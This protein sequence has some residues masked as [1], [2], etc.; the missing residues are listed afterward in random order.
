[1]RLQWIV[2]HPQPLSVQ[3]EGLRVTVTATECCRT[4]DI[5]N[6]FPVD[7]WAP[8]EQLL[9]HLRRV[10][11]SVPIVH[12]TATVHTL[13]NVAFPGVMETGECETMWFWSCVGPSLIECPFAASLVL[14][15][16]DQP[17]VSSSCHFFQIWKIMSECH[18][19][20]ADDTCVARVTLN[21]FSLTTYFN[22]Q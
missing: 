10:L 8:R 21:P 20:P 2:D 3:T 11:A 9:V 17:R 18:N 6:R 4:A 15:Q 13:H 5:L 22:I 16:S 1:M 19:F 12:H 7:Q 14:Q